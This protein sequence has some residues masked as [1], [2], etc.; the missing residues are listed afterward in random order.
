MNHD[1]SE[2]QVLETEWDRDQV[3]ELF[4]DL[5][6]GAV[7]QHVQVRMNGAGGTEDKEVELDEAR[8]LF[9]RGESKAIQIRYAFDGEVWCDTLMVGPK[10][11]RIIRTS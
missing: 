2:P 6:L 3:N 9:N 1:G 11:T 10:L 8:Q 5:S 4:H 7:V